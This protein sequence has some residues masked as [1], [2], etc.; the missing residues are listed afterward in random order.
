MKKIK[1]EKSFYGDFCEWEFTIYATISDELQCQLN[2]AKD[3]I[4]GQDFIKSINL[5]TPH[6][7]LDDEIS[8][9]LY[10]QCAYD[11]EKIAV[12]E[13]DIYFIIQGKYDSHI[14]AE[15]SVI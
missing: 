6:D 9:K 15:Y 1:L 7:F 10:A 4:K 14:Q 2:R 12:F 11:V 3:L 8:S 13:C 5:E